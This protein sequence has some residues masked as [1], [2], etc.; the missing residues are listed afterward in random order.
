MNKP[1]ILHL[2]PGRSLTGGT[3]A[4]VRSLIEQSQ[5]N[6]IV[7]VPI[8]SAREEKYTKQWQQINNCTLIEGLERKNYIRSTLKIRAII[9]QYNVDIVHSY[10]PPETIIASLVKRNMPNIKIIRSF[11]GYVKQNIIKRKIISFFLK[12]FDRIVYISHYIKRCYQNKIPTSLHSKCEVIYNAA[13]HTSIILNPVKHNIKNRKLVTVSGLNQSK[14]L[15]ILIDAVNILI[16]RKEY[17]HLDILGDGDLKDDLQAKIDSLNLQEYVT[18]LGYKDQVI[19]YLD[20]ASIYVHPANNEGFGIAV[21]EAMQ[22]Y[23]AV[24]VSDAG[25]LPE[26]ITNNIDGIIASSS[27]SLDWANKI[28]I[29]L[30]DQNLVDKLGKN[31]YNTANSKFSINSYVQKHEILYSKLVNQQ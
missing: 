13:A 16:K 19:E 7:F 11:E 26:I 23:C 10:F 20:N 8:A 21:I 9:K 28:S 18:L 12:N 25:A 30:K 17:L 31:A 22:R 24:I 2:L 29:L 6:H 3:A 15:F 14:N 5:Y 4:K 1:T 27:N